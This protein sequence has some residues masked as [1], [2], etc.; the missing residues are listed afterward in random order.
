LAV[1]ANIESRSLRWPLTH[2]E[3]A[4]TFG[5]T[6]VLFLIAFALIS[7]N[8]LDPTAACGLAAC[9]AIFAPWRETGAAVGGMH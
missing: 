2:W 8:H 4:G 9:G 7:L 3:V 6:G 1:A 5:D